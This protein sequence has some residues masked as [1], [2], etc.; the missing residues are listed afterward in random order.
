[1]DMRTNSFT[2]LEKKYFEDLFNMSTGYVLDFSNNTF[3]SFFK[4]CV[5]KDI[6]H[7]KYSVY[8]DSKAKRL[9]TFWEM[10]SDQLVGKALKG[11]LDIWEYDNSEK[12]NS[13]SKYAKCLKYLSE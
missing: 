7:N 9:R 8:G 1:M 11:M 3:A 2:S 10:E 5:N 12:A 13:D 6:Y 4:E